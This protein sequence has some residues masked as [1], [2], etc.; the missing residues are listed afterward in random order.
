MWVGMVADY[1]ACREGVGGEA[2]C[3]EDYEFGAKGCIGLELH[4][5]RLNIESLPLL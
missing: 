2:G 1:R 5:H 3:Y 4:G